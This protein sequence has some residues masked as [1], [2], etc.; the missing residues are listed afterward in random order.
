[1][2]INYIDKMCPKYEKHVTY[3]LVSR[4]QIK[5]LFEPCI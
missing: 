5:I 2:K 4:S 3:D 1:M